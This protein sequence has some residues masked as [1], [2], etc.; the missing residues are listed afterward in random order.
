[1]AFVIPGHRCHKSGR[2][3]GH[4]SFFNLPMFF[5]LTKTQNDTK[6]ALKTVVTSNLIFSCR[7]WCITNLTKMPPRPALREEWE[8]QARHRGD[9]GGGRRPRFTFKKPS[10]LLHIWIF[11]HSA[12]SWGFKSPSAHKYSHKHS[13]FAPNSFPAHR[14]MCHIVLHHLMRWERVWHKNGPFPGV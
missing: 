8:V 12:V 1:M 13:V 10:L 7:I 2:E 14:I 11:Y 3:K 4:T 6:Y 9:C 5:S